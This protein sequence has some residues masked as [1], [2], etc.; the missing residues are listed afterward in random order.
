MAALSIATVLSPI[1]TSMAAIVLT[2]ILFLAIVCL[3]V[4]VLA[5]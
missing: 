3:G 4:A 5:R 2:P 1:S